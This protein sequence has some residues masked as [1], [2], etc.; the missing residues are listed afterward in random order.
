MTGLRT[1]RTRQFVVKALLMGLVTLLY[2]LF[3]ALSANAAITPVFPYRFSEPEATIHIKAGAY[4]TSVWQKAIQVWNSKHVFSFDLTPH[5]SAQITATSLP[6]S[7]YQPD[8]SGLTSIE[9]TADNQIITVTTYINTSVVKASHYT[10]AQRVHVAEHELGH[11]MGLN[12]NPGQK[13][14]MYYAN[15]YY[16]VQAVDVAAVKAHYQVG[17]NGTPLPSIPAG[18]TAIKYGTRILP[19]LNQTLGDEA[20]LQLIMVPGHR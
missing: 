10:T 2:S 1:R 7:L 3:S 5:T 20:D 11:A 4:Y 16:P 18:D 12:H 6:A 8:L 15:R 17:A 9:H 13:S 19:L 14:V